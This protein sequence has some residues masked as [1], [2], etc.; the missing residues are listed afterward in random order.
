[1]NT[2]FK[3]IIT[4]ICTLA[5]L[6]IAG[7]V[8]HIGNNYNPAT[9]DQVK[10]LIKENAPKSLTIDEVKK[11]VEENIL[12][13]G[14][15]KEIVQKETAPIADAIAKIKI[16]APMRPEEIADAIKWPTN[17][18]KEIADG[19]KL[20]QAAP[21]NPAPIIK[22]DPVEFWNAGLQAARE[23]K[24]RVGGFQARPF[25]DTTGFLVFKLE[26]KEE[27]NGEG[28]SAPAETQAPVAGN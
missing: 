28:R 18:A 27:G 15:I 16:P 24:I 11:I 1:M 5:L 7:W 8:A 2:K 14:D 25:L 26:S 23:G 21:V 20:P 13:T 12:G 19:V 3:Y 4:V 17:L 10:S 9:A 22:L 6:S